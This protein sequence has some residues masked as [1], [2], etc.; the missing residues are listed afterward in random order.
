MSN[1]QQRYCILVLAAGESRRYGSAKQLAEIKGTPMVRYVTQRLIAPDVFRVVIVLGAR[2]D[3]IRPVI[4]DLEVDIVENPEW[5]SGIATSIFAGISYISKTFPQAEG[6]VI[7]LGDQWKI[8]GHHIQTL[9]RTAALH[10]N[11]IIATDYDGSPGVPVFFPKEKWPELMSLTGDE[12][13]KQLLQSR[14][15]VRLLN[16]L[17]A[18]TDLDYPDDL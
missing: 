5:E 7:V 4:A 6:L 2:A 3:L 17:E 13:A 8:A 1:L 16:L 15:D 14:S 12:G 9:L 10:P 11:L 18:K